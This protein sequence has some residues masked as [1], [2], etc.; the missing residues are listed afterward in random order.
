M[1]LGVVDVDSASASG[2]GEEDEDE[3]QSISPPAE[4]V[5]VEVLPAEVLP[6]KYSR[7]AVFLGIVVLDG[8]MCLFCLD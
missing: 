5:S 3:G 4:D 7:V 8:M 1:S 2:L 6:A